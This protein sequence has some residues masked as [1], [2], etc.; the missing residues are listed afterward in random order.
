MGSRISF[1]LSEFVLNQ[2][3]EVSL[4]TEVLAPD[5]EEGIPDYQCIA[6]VTFNSSVRGNLK[7]DFDVD[8][9]S[10]VVTLSCDFNYIRYEE[11]SPQR[12]M[13]RRLYEA[14]IN[15]NITH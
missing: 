15:F 5:E 12:E 9:N 3:A 4:K 6:T 8:T 11:G 1:R 2:Y 7:Y 14:G 10:G 13:F